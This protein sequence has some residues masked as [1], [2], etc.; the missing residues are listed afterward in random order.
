MFKVHC[1]TK[2]IMIQAIIDRQIAYV[3]ETDKIADI[4]IAV[5]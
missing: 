3:C 5:T 4:H 2:S 1:Y